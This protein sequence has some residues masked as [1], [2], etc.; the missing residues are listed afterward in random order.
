ME[1]DT[2]HSQLNLNKEQKKVA[3]PL[4]LKTAMEVAGLPGTSKTKAIV[5][6]V[7]LS[8]SAQAIM[9]LCSVSK[10]VQSMQW[11]KN[12]RTSL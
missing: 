3:R 8:C 7:W 11:L 9:Y 10:M 2:P 5:E 6:L 1:M 12:S 4:S